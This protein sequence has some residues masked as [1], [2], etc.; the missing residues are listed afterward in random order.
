M[1]ELNKRDELVADV[2]ALARVRRLILSSAFKGEGAQAV[3]SALTLLSFLNEAVL[4]Q[5]HDDKV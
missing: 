4:D 1:E 3:V 2:E 5:L